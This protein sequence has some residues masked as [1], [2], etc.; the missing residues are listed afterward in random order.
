MD[1]SRITTDHPDRTPSV[2]ATLLAV[3]LGASTFLLHYPFTV[4]GQDAA[5]RD[6]GLTL[7]L[8]FTAVCWLRATRHRR[9]FLAAFALFAAVLVVESF[10]FG[11]GP[12]GSL[13]WPWWNEKITG[14]LMLVCAAVGWSRAPAVERTLQSAA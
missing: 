7:A 6:R 2:L 9:A 1:T 4:D 12:N 11:Y 5:L 13:G 10:A 14:V 8:L 3:W